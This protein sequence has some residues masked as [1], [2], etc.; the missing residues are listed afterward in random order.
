VGI[1][2]GLGIAKLLGISENI[3]ALWTG[4]TL[5]V[6]G[7]WVIFCMKKK[8]ITN[9]LLLSTAFLSSYIPLIAVYTGKNPSVIFNENK[10]LFI[11]SFIFYMILGS[12]TVLFSEKYYIHIRNKRGKPH[13]PYEKVVLPIVGLIITSLIINFLK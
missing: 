7:C 11:D 6:L 13:F 10:V 2:S 1:A 3:I 4:S 8:G 12:L 9:K 5:F